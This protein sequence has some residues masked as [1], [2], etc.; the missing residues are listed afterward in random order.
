MLRAWVAALLLAN[1]L[2][3]GWARGWWSPALPPPVHGEREPERLT[4]QVKPESVRFVSASAVAAATAPVCLEAGPFT[5]TDI[6]MAE[7]A[8]L[9][10][11]VPAS[12]WTRRTEP[13]A[14]VLALV[15]GRFADPA[16]L[17]AKEDELRRRG[18]AFE[19]LRAPPEL[20]PGLVLSRHDDEAAAEQALAALGQKGVRTARI[21]TLPA[22]ARVWLRAERAEGAV[23][24][25]L[26]A[27]RPPVL[28][29]PF[30]PCG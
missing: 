19:E 30:A 12:A 1:L 9:G 23:K 15:M 16:A 18:V 2:F 11:G 20:V 17:R 27:L 25:K 14:P 8:L 3:F 13:G 7:A 24:A 4:A 28:A 22:P 26:S 10:A 5:D 21:A 6:G 29:L